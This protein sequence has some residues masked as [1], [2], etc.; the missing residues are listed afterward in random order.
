MD[1]SLLR[2]FSEKKIQFSY[3]KVFLRFFKKS[4]QEKGNF[5]R[6]DSTVEFGRTPALKVPLTTDLFFLW[7]AYTTRNG[8]KR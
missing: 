8:D 2:V 4:F 5:N 6:D 1:N 7:P 3:R